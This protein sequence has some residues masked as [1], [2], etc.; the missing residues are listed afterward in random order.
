MSVLSQD[1]AFG[2]RQHATGLRRS[3]VGF[4]ETAFAKT[5]RSV[6]LKPFGS[7]AP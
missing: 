5:C 6:G 7:A 4:S 2:F 3:P 1:A